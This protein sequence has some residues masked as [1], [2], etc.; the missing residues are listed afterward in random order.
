MVGSSQVV[1]LTVSFEGT[2]QSSRTEYASQV[3]KGESE[4]WGDYCM[5]DCRMKFLL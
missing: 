2:F 3:V 5:I 4:G 1:M